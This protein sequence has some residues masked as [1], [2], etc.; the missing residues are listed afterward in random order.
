MAN[1]DTSSIEDAVIRATH[2]ILT[3]PDWSANIGICD[4]L[5][6]R[7]VH[8]AQ[9][10]ST[11]R[12]RLRHKQL[13]V[14]SMAIEL[15]A[16]LM[17]NNPEVRIH[18]AEMDFLRFLLDKVPKK[19]KEPKARFFLI[20]NWTY[21]QGKAR[22]DYKSSRPTRSTE[23]KSVTARNANKSFSDRECK[24]AM[25]ASKVLEE[26]LTAS[27]PKKRIDRDDLIKTL[28]S[29]VAGAQ[30]SIAKR[31]S[32]T[33]NPAILYY[34]GLVNGT[35]KRIKKSTKPAQKEK[36]K[37]SSVGRTES[38]S[39]KSK[40]MSA[41]RVAKLKKRYLDLKKLWKKDKSDKDA[42]R[43]MRE[44]KRKWEDAKE[45][46]EDLEDEEETPAE[47]TNKSK[48]PKKKESKLSKKQYKAPQAAIFNLAPPPGEPGFEP[49]EPPATIPTTSPIPNTNADPNPNPNPNPNAGGLLFDLMDDN[50]VGYQGTSAPTDP[51]PVV[52]ETAAVAQEA[53][54][55]PFAALANRHESP[56]TQQTN[57]STKPTSTGNDINLFMDAFQ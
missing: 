30:N 54:D 42:R 15:L 2:E 34:K 45:E 41:E 35:M 56:S 31:V 40:K 5:R 55:D 22:R 13:S 28:L 17:K 29:Q 4:W 1:A 48:S 49:E 9:A 25:E 6:R 10:K 46:L 37:A 12:Q 53:D 23:K 50:D 3:K 24:S 38:K 26:M 57:G 7:P 39:S 32:N 51:S 36:K 33:A 44:A 43:A 8:I 27:D 16:T 14:Q 52:A 47:L 19:L 20:Q 11:I 18:F 21:E